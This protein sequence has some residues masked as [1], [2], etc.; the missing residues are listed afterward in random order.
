VFFTAKDVVGHR[1]RDKAGVAVGR[2]TAFYRYPPELSATSGVAA[3][4]LG[5]ILRSTHLVDL[6]DARLDGDEVVAAYPVALIK[7]APNHQALVGDTLSDRH[8][9]EVLQHY[10][11]GVEADA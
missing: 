7:T 3:V 9:A 8:A 10:K 6:L 11:G 5:R 4:T 2:V 1:M